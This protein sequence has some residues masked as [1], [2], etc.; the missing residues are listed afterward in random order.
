MPRFLL[1]SLL[2]FVFFLLSAVVAV[3]DNGALLIQIFTSLINTERE[4]YLLPLAAT[5]ARRTTTP[6]FCRI[7]SDSPID[8]VG[9]AA[10]LESPRQQQTQTEKKM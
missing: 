2:S 1:F 9:L 5:P 6:T 8:N 4:P 10:I 3:V 7:R